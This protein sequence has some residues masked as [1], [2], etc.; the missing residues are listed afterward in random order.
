MLKFDIVTVA[1]V[2]TLV[3][4]VFI[5][6]AMFKSF[7]ENPKIA[8]SEAPLQKNKEF[9][10]QP[11]EV[12]RY[13]YIM[14]NTTANMTFLILDGMGCTRIRV[15]EE[16]NG[17]D[18]CLDRWGVDENGSNV[19]FSN[20]N[21]LLFKPW[22]LALKE[23]WTWNNTMY[24]AFNGSSEYITDNYYRVIR[25]E[26]YSGRQSYIVEI[27]SDTGAV[28]YDWVDDE[29]RVLLRVLGEGY[30]VVLAED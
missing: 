15:A 22:M 25:M 6:N 5:G 21:I 10:L 28:E 16:R 13:A 29:K 24:L 3:M 4:M 19:S 2:A 17:T 23:G 7:F 27:K 18:V 9:S 26:N 12:Y 1:T 11:G 8:Y 20:P 30:E 14:N